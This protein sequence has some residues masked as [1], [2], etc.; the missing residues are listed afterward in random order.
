MWY[1]AALIAIMAIG[2]VAY[3]LALKSTADKLPGE[4][5]KT[6]QAVEKVAALEK[7]ANDA[8]QSEHDQ[9]VAESKEVLKSGDVEHA[10]GFLRSS[11]RRPPVT[12]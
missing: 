6:R 1:A 10:I 2:C 4:Q 12:R 11:V 9:D 8:R 3:I 7:T 5:A